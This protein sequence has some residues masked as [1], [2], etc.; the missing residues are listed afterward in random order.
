MASKTSY[1]YQKELLA[2]FRNQIDSFK[3]ELTN[4]AYNFQN[5]IQNI[6]ENDG[7]MDEVYE[8]YSANFLQP[9][10]NTIEEIASRIENEDYAFIQKEEDFLNCR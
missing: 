9:T 5:S 1:A 2:N 4:V 10:I 6:H 3:K 8:E 7:L